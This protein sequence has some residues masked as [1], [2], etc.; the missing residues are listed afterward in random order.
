MQFNALER[1]HDSPL[2]PNRAEAVPVSIPGP[3]SLDP[4]PEFEIPDQQPAPD[5]ADEPIHEQQRQIESSSAAGTIP[6]HDT[7]PDQAPG[8]QEKITNLQEDEASAALPVADQGELAELLLEEP[9]N[10]AGNGTRW[11]WAAG[12]VLVLLA[13]MA[14]FVWFQRDEVLSRYP[15]LIPWAERMCARLDCNVIRFRDV[16]A[17][18][19]INRDVREHPRY[20]HALL[21]NA[22]MSNQS[23]TRQP[24]P[25]IQ[26]SLYDTEG[27]LISHR[28][29]TPREYLDDSIDIA[30]GMAPNIPVHFVL[31]VTGP[32]EGAVSFEFKFL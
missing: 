13:G 8:Q 17:I 29:F 25:D 14:Q 1:L 28:I 16:S 27:S 21:V 5:P 6:A 11:W 22:T 30:Q 18:K 9:E 32:T 19:L 23:S 2:P 7:E 20:E 15:A 4:E 26:L 10:S 31:E 12:A 3:D 24:Y